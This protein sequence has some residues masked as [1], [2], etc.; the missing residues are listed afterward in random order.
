[1]GIVY[2]VKTAYFFALLALLHLCGC[3]SRK[4][5]PKGNFGLDENGKY[6]YVAISPSGKRS[7]VFGSHDKCVEY[8]DKHS[9]DFGDGTVIYRGERE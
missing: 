4:E 6:E 8:T 1:M 9:S 7:P 5:I 2:G 3:D